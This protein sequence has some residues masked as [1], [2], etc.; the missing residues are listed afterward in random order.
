ME[1]ENAKQ[2]LKSNIKFSVILI[3]LLCLN[4]YTVFQ[5]KKKSRRSKK[6]N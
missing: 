6:Y 4:I 3:V 1:K 5:I 2:Q